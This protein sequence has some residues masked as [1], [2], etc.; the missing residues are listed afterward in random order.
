M[1]WAP[2]TQRGPAAFDVSKKSSRGI[3]DPS[4]E[5]PGPSRHVGVSLR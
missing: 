4:A 1:K 5:R 2:G 3:A